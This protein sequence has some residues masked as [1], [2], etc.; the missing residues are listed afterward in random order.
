M[1]IASF[2]VDDKDGKSCFFQETF[3]LADVSMDVAFEILFFILSN[4]KVNS[5]Y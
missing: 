4:V 5:N 2:Q 1:I 3:L